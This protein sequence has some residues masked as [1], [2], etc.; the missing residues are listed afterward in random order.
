MDCEEFQGGRR[1]LLD[2]VRNIEGARKWVDFF[3][4]GGKEEM[5][6]LLSGEKVEGVDEK[7]QELVGVCVMR[8]REWWGKRKTV[9]FKPP[10]SMSVIMS[11]II[12]CWPNGSM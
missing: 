5:V 10:P 6:L 11:V 2:R 7:V 8:V 4:S 3:E 1:L 12:S 9:L